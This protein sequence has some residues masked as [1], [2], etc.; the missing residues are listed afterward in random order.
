VKKVDDLEIESYITCQISLLEED[1]LI[2]SS[3]Q[4]HN[5]RFSAAAATTAIAA[6]AAAAAAATKM[7]Y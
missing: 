7:V 1:N 6:A 3:L 2:L 5:Q 4:F